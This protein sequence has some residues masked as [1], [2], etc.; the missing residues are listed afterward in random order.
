MPWLTLRWFEEGSNETKKKVMELVT[1]VIV[2]VCGH[3]SEDL[4]VV[5]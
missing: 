3:K 2:D 4:F 5:F 1:S